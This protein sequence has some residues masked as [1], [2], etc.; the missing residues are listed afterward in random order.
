MTL[1]HDHSLVVGELGETAPAMPFR[2]I[3]A[4]DLSNITMTGPATA[5]RSGGANHAYMI[6]SRANP[7]RG[8]LS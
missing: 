2:P 6:E 1:T 3:P 4:L 5:P 7:C 8:F